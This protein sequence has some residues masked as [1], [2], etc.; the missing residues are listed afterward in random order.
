MGGENL[1]VCVRD[2]EGERRKDVW[3]S[4][5]DVIPYMAPVGVALFVM[6]LLEIWDLHVHG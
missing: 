4:S 5:A 2:E 3:S 6:V 1:R